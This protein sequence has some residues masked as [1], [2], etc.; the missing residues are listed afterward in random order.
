MCTIHN[1]VSV[2]PINF[3]KQCIYKYPSCNCICSNTSQYGSV[4]CANH[5]SVKKIYFYYCIKYETFDNSFN[6]IN[7]HVYET[8]DECI[9]EAKIYADKL[10]NHGNKNIYIIIYDNHGYKIRVM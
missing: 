6:Q 7:S 4:Y 9:N 10:I 1:L 2:S 5:V 8:S 3:N